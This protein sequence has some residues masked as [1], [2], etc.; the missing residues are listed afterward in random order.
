[1]YKLDVMVHYR[2]TRHERPG[3]LTSDVDMGSTPGAT[4]KEG[5]VIVAVP[6][7]RYVADAIN[8]YGQGDQ[9]S[10]GRETF[11]VD[12]YAGK[13]ETTKELDPLGILRHCKWLSTYGWKPGEYRHRLEIVQI[14][15]V[16]EPL[17]AF[18]G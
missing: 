14:I 6:D 10:L 15:K 17:P 3:L 16:F 8:M 13:H 2:V 4:V 7:W 12:T 11:F 9:Q 1:V 18:D 5:A